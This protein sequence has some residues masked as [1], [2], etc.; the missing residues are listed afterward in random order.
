MAV[1]ASI[2]AIPE[3]GAQLATK[4]LCS[5]SFILSVYCIIACAVAQQFG[6]RLRSLDFAVRL[7]FFSTWIWRSQV[8]RCTTYKGRWPVL[9][10]W[11][12]YQAFCLW[13]GKQSFIAIKY[14]SHDPCSLAFSILGFIAGVFT[15]DFALSLATR[16]GCRLA[17]VVGAGLITPLMIAS[18]GPGLIRW[19]RGEME[20]M[21]NSIA[22]H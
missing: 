20:Q 10:Y 16:I 21:N 13:Q 14:H 7:S 2:L 3:L 19:C 1:D 12:V 9:Q 17:L 6:H 11:R 4:T 5:I 8:D 22:Y 18:F 15:V